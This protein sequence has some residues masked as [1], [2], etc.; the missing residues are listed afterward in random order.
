M[1]RQRTIIAERYELIEQAGEGG[2]AIVWRAAMHGAAGFSRPVA[3]KRIKPEFR[4]IKNYT[5]MFIEEAR[6]GAELQHPNIVQVFDFVIEAD[7]SYYLIMEWVQ[8]ID[9]GRFVH[10]YARMGAPTP[11]GLIV[12][13]CVGALRG[14]AAAHE[15]RA[16]DGTVAPVIHRDVSPH[17]IL[18]GENGIAKLTDFGLARARDRVISLTAPGTVKGK[19]SFLSPEVTRGR[20]ATEHSDLFS[21][22]SVLWE[23]LAGRRLFDGPSDLDVFRKIRNGEVAPLAP[24]RPDL[25]ARLVAAVE[26][27][28][29]LEP[30]ARFPSAR[31]MANELA[32][33]L[34][35]TS[36][37][38]DAQTLLGQRVVE[39]RGRLGIT[40]A[41]TD[42]PH[43]AQAL[44]AGG[45]VD[46][47]F[48]EVA[49]EPS[50]LDIAFSDPEIES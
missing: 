30:Q 40:R 10:S 24:E 29:A 46:V 15:R 8:G 6:V 22:G 49:D 35:G 2:M 12:A 50:G 47:E 48:S 19:V 9:L 32:D 4:A 38:Q 23:A 3:V 37:P 44:A 17:N 25:P 11:W 31:A 1:V 45:S 7:G 33:V 36:A 18:L 16:P 28:L 5:A 41:P 26:R 42:D 43:L 27:A 34:K 20:P 21:M 14:L 39:A 13:A